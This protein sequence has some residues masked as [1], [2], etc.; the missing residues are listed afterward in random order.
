[1]S[2]KPLIPHIFAW[3]LPLQGRGFMGSQVTRVLVVEDQ[4]YLREMVVDILSEYGYP[5][6]GSADPFTALAQVAALMPELVV[7]DMWMPSMSGVTFIARL[8]RDPR[9]AALPVIVVSGD[10]TVSID[11]LG[12]AHV[13]FILKPFE[14]SVLVERTRALIGPPLC[15]TA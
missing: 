10:R 14:A 4:D 7:L 3:A 11:K 13:E 6:A 15:I 5:A 12:D 9:F 8:R 2:G 1:V